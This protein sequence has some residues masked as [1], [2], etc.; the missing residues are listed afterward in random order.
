MVTADKGLLRRIRACSERDAMV[1]EALA[2]IEK[3]GPARLQH[4]L[5]DW[6]T[7]TGLILYRGKVYVP[8]DDAL[9]AEIVKVHHDSP[10]AGHPG[11]SKTLELVTRNYWWPGMMQFVKDYVNTCDTCR[12]TKAARTQPAGP[13]KPNEVPDGPGQVVTCDFITGLPPCGGNSA[14]QI[15]V[16]RHSKICRLIPCTDTI[17]SIGTAENFVRHWFSLYGLPR[18]IISDRGPQFASDLFR[19]M[20]KR[21]GVE[22]GLSTAFHPQTDGQTERL[23][24]E[25]ET[26]L[27]AFCSHRRDDWASWIPIAEYALN[28]REHSAT[29]HSPFYLLYG[30]NPSFT[31][32]PTPT[33][34][35]SA[36]DRIANLQD[37]RADATAA[38]NLA[39][40]RM[41]SYFDRHVTEAPSFEPGQKVWL[42]TRNL[43]FKGIP[44]KLA[45]KFAGPYPVKRRVGELA[46][47]LKLPSDL[48]VHPVFHVSLLR[49]HR[50]STLPGRHP[51]EPAP[52]DV[53]GEEEYEV[54]RI[55][56]SR[57]HGRWRSLQ[58]LVQWKGYGPE[59]NQWLPATA[60]K[61]APVL[62]R[63]FHRTHPRSPAPLS[64]TS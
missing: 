12:Q 43:S 26:Y 16:D 11:Q 28:S 60:V 14:L 59:H 4:D 13:L 50:A 38:L 19:A 22:S 62:I 36:N 15:I 55:L 1:T 9:R 58:Y 46:Y 53:D 47:E 25:I 27:R 5:S 54:E 57:R 7:D 61:H 63:E 17:D 29:G 51:S 21:L 49:A 23:N 64:R 52:I 41:K 18:K 42:D 10:P 33:A 34:L 37:A 39:A 3:L 44:R 45:D 24:Q 20:L 48:K 32:N 8:K 30:Y 31:V 6:N 56:D 2:T 40:E 35:P